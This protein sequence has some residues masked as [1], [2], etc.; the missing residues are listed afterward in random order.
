MPPIEDEPQVSK[1]ISDLIAHSIAKNNNTLFE[2]LTE[3]LDSTVVQL[4]RAHA[5]ANEEQTKE[6]K[7]LKTNPHKEFK[8]KGN[9]IQYKFNA[10]LDEVFEDAKDAINAKKPG[11]AIEALDEGMVLIQDRQKLILLADKSEFGWKTAA[12]Y[13]QHELA[14][15]EADEKK[16]RRAEE[17]AEK[18]TRA[19]RS[20][21][22]IN[23]QG[24]PS[25]P[26]LAQNRL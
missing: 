17:R 21:L 13:E 23:L 26:A 5:E 1:A 8:R 4:K 19:V 20:G 10:K 7:R 22:Y 16:I 24:S 2:R 14:K 11:K 25:G 15:D 18:A 12:E 3:K 9:E 6:I